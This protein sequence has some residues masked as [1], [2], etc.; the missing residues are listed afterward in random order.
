VRVAS[1]VVAPPLLALL[2]SVSTTGTLPRPPL[3]PVFDTSSAA[4]LATELSTLYPSR[5]PGTFGAEDAAFW[6]RERIAG[7]GLTAE[8]D[9]WTADLPDLGEIE[10][11]NV[12][13]VIR[14][15]SEE[16]ILLVAHRDNTGLGRPFGDNASGT[17]ALIEIAR[18]YAPQ[19]NVPTPLPERTLILLSTDA[20]AYGGAGA[21]RFAE[22]SRY[23][24]DLLAAIVLDG[25]GGPGRPRLAIA[26]DG[27][28]SPA[29]ALVG[30]ASARVA[31]QTG[32]APAVSPV[33]TQLVDLG[34]PYAAGEQGRFLVQDVAAIALTTDEGGD[35]NVPVGD[36]SAPLVEERLGQLGRAT[37]ALVSSLDESVGATFRA[38]DSVFL[39]DRAASGWTVRLTLVVAVVPFF[40]GVLDLLV[41]SRR[42]RVALLPALRCLRARFLLWAYGGVLLGVGALTGVFPTGASLPVPPYSSFVTDWPIS[43][44]AVLVIAFLLGWLV[45]RR[46]LLPARRPS[47]E[48]RLAGYT[49]ALTWLAATAVVVALVRPYALVFVL[50]SLY[51]WLWLPLRTRF[52]PRVALYLAGLA[53]PVGGLLLLSHELGLGPGDAILY[54][55]G[56]V[57]VGYVPVTSVVLALAWAAAAAQLA[58]L[59][60]GR[61]APYADGAEPP[62][63][64][65]VR[66]VLALARSRRKR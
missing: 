10:L 34:V 44:L 54:V 47:V 3:E 64:G 62:P 14:G 57:T 26:G 42:R 55:V 30:T 8:E 2:F 19:E 43:G 21:A 60:F 4:A 40:L 56:L 28:R 9:V 33:L 17:A 41:R 52:W 23:A 53:G 61:Y 37:E 18:G 29:R 5:V 35:P 1:I 48:E 63:P 7:L 12:A 50:P 11:R 46:R 13:T 32:R 20:G 22:D 51:A 16:A 36:A 38:H 65:P 45:A 25:V 66:S 59:A 6:Y 24:D 58:A 49:A 27:A 39:E 31:E 15:R